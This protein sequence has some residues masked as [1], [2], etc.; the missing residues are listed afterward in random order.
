MHQRLRTAGTEI[1]VSSVE[2]QEL[3][4]VFHLKPRIGQNITSH[5]CF[6][7]AKNFFLALISTFLVHSPSLFS[8][9]PHQSDF[10]VT[11]RTPQTP[12]CGYRSF[13]FFFFLFFTWNA[14]KY[15]VHKLL[16]K[17]LLKG[18]I[19]RGG[20]SGGVYVYSHTR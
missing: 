14:S 11:H 5:A 12:S 9:N 2:N 1:K 4:T 8:R 16:Q 18:Y 15:K 17:Y 7:T 3:T 6:A 10:D 20:T 19:V 13:F